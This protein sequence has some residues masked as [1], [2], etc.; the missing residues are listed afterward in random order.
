MSDKRWMINWVIVAAGVWLV[1]FIAGDALVSIVPESLRLPLH[2]ASGIVI[3]L[4]V[5]ALIMANRSPFGW[6]EIAWRRVALSVFVTAIFLFALFRP[7]M[8][9]HSYREGRNPRVECTTPHS[10]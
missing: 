5:G 4:S 3:G 9:C 1:Y 10:P 7:D 6:S 8:E 2:H